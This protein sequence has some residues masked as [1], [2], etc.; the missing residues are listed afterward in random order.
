[1]TPKEHAQDASTKDLGTQ[2]AEE[3]T[4]LALKRS[5]L[6]CERTLMAW[7]RTAFAMISFGFT[8]IKFFQYLDTSRGPAVGLL[9]RT[10]TPEVV[11]F[12]MMAIGTVSLCVAVF[13][14]RRE[15]KEL[16]EAGLERRRSLAFIVASLVALLGVFAFVSVFL[17][18]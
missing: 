2:L 9:G 3:R 14:H 13:D 5:F 10:W 7:M 16:R 12:A 18:R 15:L 17:D 11:G 1:M 6:A 4:A 8:M